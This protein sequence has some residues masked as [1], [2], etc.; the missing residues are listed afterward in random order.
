MWHRFRLACLLAAL[1]H[2]PAEGLVVKRQETVQVAISSPED[3][4]EQSLF[5]IGGVDNF[6]SS[7]SPTIDLCRDGTTLVGLR[8]VGLGIP[9]DAT[10]DSAFVTLF[11]AVTDAPDVLS[12]ELEVRGLRL[13]EPFQQQAGILSALLEQVVDAQVAWNDFP[14]SVP[15][16]PFESSDISL[17]VQKIIEDGAANEVEAVNELALIFTGAGPNRGTLAFE[18]NPALAAR[19]EVTYTVAEGNFVLEATGVVLVFAGF[20]GFFTFQRRRKG[21]NINK[22]QVTKN[23]AGLPPG[24][25]TAM[26]SFPHEAPTHEFSPA[27]PPPPMGAPPTPPDKNHASFKHPS[28]MLGRS[29]VQIASLARKGGKKPETLSDFV[30]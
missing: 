8:F 7:D 4:V 30:V 15:A 12:P 22:S 2:Y 28:L 25:L 6:F 3:D 1:F 11:G 17:V 13:D 9:A 16:Q 26:K 29:W 21:I 5:A 27:P 24:D 23:I 19:L 20:V 10:I 14:P 18:T